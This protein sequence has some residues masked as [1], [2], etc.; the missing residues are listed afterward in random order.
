MEKAHSNDILRRAAQGRQILPV[1]PNI[2]DAVAL[3]IIS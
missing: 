2:A 3:A 1:S